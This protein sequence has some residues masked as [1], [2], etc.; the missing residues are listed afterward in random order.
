MSAKN[1][2]VYQ[3]FKDKSL[4]TSFTSPVTFI[5]YTDNVSYQIVVTTTNSTGNFFLEVSDDYTEIQTGIPEN[6]GNWHRLT[7]SGQPN[8]AAA[9]D[10]IG[11]SLNQLP[12]A[13]IRLVYVSTVAGTGTCDVTITGKRLGG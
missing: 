13:A 6:V 7:L 5:R 4:A 12:Y 10:V 8:V 1:T 3:L 9:N 11:I 2:L